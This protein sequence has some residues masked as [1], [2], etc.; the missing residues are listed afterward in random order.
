MAAQ[1]V[2]S[3]ISVQAKQESFQ[4]L[5]DLLSIE[6]LS[7]LHVAGI[8]SIN[9]FSQLSKELIPLSP[10]L[11]PPR[12]QG[13]DLESRTLKEQEMEPSFPLS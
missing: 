5:M 10:P 13:S 9:S 11:V 3:L 2:S 12:T 4:S 1:Q 8:P 7:S 6:Q